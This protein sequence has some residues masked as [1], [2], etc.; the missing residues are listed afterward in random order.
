MAVMSAEQSD[1]QVRRSSRL[2]AAA[3]ATPGLAELPPLMRSKDLASVLGMK[4][5]TV[6]EWIRLGRIPASKIGRSYIVRREALI[7]FLER[8][9]RDR[10]RSNGPGRAVSA[11]LEFAPRLR[12]RRALESAEASD[13]LAKE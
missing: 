10:A 12:R 9:E 8:S 1:V 4:V 11:L 7:S 13:S 2:T 3:G 6:N 5:H